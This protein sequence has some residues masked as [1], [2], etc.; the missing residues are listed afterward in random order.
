M[1]IKTSVINGRS[2]VLIKNSFGNPFATFL[3]NNYETVHVVDYRYFNKGLLNLIKSEG[4]DDVIFFHN[5]FS[6]NTLSHT[7]R[8]RIIKHAITDSGSAKNSANTKAKKENKS[9][10]TNGKQLS[11]TIK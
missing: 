9:G 8:Q 10:D 4:I 3:V 6:A 11:D 2:V 7:Q 1:K 5:V